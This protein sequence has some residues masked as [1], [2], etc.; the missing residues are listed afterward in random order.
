MK[1]YIIRHG[2]TSANVAGV[3]QGRLDTE[4]L[5]SGLALASSV[6]QALSDVRFDA[7]FASPLT[8]SQITARALLDASGNEDVPIEID[9]R[10]FEI[11]VGQCEGKHFRPGECEVDEKYLHG[12]FDDPL[13]FDGFPEGESTREVCARTQDFLRELA[14]KDYES[15]LVST[16]GF[17]LRAMLNMVYDDPSDFW[18]GG[19]PLN[20]SVS[21]VDA[22]DGCFDLVGDDVVFY[23]QS[24]VSDWFSEH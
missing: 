4:L 24:Q 8:R 18:H 10:L 2:E 13:H 3:F 16:H 19:V 5:E 20:C 1:I 7:A 12:Y 17:A 9:E 14:Q 11:S 15:V 23:D 22:H 21:I 6:G